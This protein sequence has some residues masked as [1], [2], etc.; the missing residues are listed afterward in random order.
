MNNAGGLG[1]FHNNTPDQLFD[2]FRVFDLQGNTMFAD[3][4]DDANVSQSRWKL[5]D[6]SGRN[7]D[8]YPIYRRAYMLGNKAPLVKKTRYVLDRHIDE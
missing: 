5:T 8:D 1:L 7:P 6:G 2:N 3:N 4:F